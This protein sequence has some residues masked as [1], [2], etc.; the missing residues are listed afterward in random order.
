MSFYKGSSSWENGQAVEAEFYALLLLRDPEARK[1]TQQEQ[2]NH[3][4]YVSYHGTFDVKAM[5][6]LRRNDHRQQGEF[7]WLELNNVR[8]EVGWLLAEDMDYLAFERVDDFIIVRREDVRLLAKELCTFNYVS[9][10][11]DALYNLYS[12]NGRKDL[13]TVIR[14]DDMLV[15]DHRLWAK[16]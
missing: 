8:G 12:R 1:A 13:L 16:S 11:G 3:V 7:R 15:L 4:D 9:S 6:Q 5:G 10:A 2:F 14:T